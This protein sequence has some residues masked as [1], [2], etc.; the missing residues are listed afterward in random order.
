M[1]H[2]ITPLPRGLPAHKYTY[3]GDGDGTACE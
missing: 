3:D 1:R 2:R